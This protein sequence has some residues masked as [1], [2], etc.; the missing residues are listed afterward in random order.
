MLSLSHRTEERATVPKTRVEWEVP[1]GLKG[2]RKV[3]R[4]CL[5]GE[6]LNDGSEN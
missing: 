3:Q 2:Q 6:C 5:C 4:A 1:I